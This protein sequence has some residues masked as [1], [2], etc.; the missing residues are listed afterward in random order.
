M[1]KQEAFVGE[2]PGR[3]DR[4]IKQCPNCGEWFSLQDV[5]ENPEIE[6]LG[7]SFE[8]ADSELNVYYFRHTSERCGTSFVIPVYEFAGLVREPMHANILRGTTECESHCTS[9]DDLSACSQ[10][11]LYAPFRR[12]LLSMLRSDISRQHETVA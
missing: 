10:Q 2:E 9:V 12:L 7:M 5:L 4:P 11:C 6:P 8:N 3:K 1:R